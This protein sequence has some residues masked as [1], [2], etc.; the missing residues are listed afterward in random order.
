M[1]P[2]RHRYPYEYLKQ[3]RKVEDLLYAVP[4]DRWSAIYRSPMWAQVK[5]AVWRLDVETLAAL[6]GPYSARH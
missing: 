1:R 4:I 3:A 2:R 6:L 5:S